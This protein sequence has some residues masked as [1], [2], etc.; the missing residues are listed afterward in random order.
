MLQ[1][2][3]P[4]KTKEGSSGRR[5][6]NG[7]PLGNGI[8]DDPMD[9]DSKS[10]IDSKRPDDLPAPD[11]PMGLTDSCFLYEWFCLFWDIYNAQRAKGGNGTVNQ[12]VAHTQVRA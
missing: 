4:V 5:D 8:G 10:D 7:N 12:Y 3:C 1:S 6:E 2:D 11:V 9:M